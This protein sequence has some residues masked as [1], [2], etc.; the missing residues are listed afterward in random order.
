[1][2]DVYSEHARPATCSAAAERSG[3]A[4]G[5]KSCRR[6]NGSGH[7]L[8]LSDV[9]GRFQCIWDGAEQQ[10]VTRPHRGG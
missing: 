2:K 4:W 6:H 1:M 3:R 7:M 10:L 9:R 8:R 5:V